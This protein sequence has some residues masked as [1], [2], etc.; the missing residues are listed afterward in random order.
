MPSEIFTIPSA[1]KKK[2]GLVNTISPIKIPQKPPMK[3]NI[4]MIPSLRVEGLLN[5]NFDFMTLLNIER[6]YLDPKNLRNK[7]LN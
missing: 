4:V 7:F 1:V 5:S 2:F 3:K 6:Y